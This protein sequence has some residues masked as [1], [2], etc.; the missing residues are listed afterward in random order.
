MYMYINYMW[1]P[2]SI[3]QGKPVTSSSTAPDSDVTRA[4]DLDIDTCMHTM[5]E[6]K[7]WLTVDHEQRQPIASVRFYTGNSSTSNH[8]LCHWNIIIILFRPPIFTDP[9]S[10]YVL[11]AFEIYFITINLAVIPLLYH[12]KCV[13]D[14]FEIYDPP[15]PT[16]S[17]V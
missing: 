4:N 11:I 16:L 5:P 13:T 10:T 6:V 7:P 14:T 17:H 12:N 1:T 3:A 2:G 8:V 9:E 15:F